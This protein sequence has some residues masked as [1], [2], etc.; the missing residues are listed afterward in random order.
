[1]RAAIVMREEW[2]ML[3]KCLRN[4]T[5]S[6]H[7]WSLPVLV[8]LAIKVYPRSKSVDDAFQKLLLSN[9]LPLCSRRC[10]DSID[11]YLAHPDVQRLFDYYADALEQIFAF[12]ATSDKRT[13]KSAAA[14][15]LRSPM[16][17][18]TGTRNSMKEVRTQGHMYQYML[19]R[20]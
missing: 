1:V 10:P 15:G 18:G 16:R 7:I 12:Y 3:V 8:Q 17:A 4:L 11:M 14:P 20:N 13:P 19:W 6:E 9:V 5:R 2:C